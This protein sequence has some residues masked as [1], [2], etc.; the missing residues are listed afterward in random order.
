MKPEFVFLLF[1]VVAVMGAWLLS[2]ILNPE[3]KNRRRRGRNYGRV[4]SQKHRP[5]VRLAVKAARS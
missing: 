2:R 5:T 3:A 1:A 4:I